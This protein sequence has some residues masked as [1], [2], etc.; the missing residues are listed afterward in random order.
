M[1]N[2]LSLLRDFFPFGNT[3]LWDGGLGDIFGDLKEKRNLPL[4]YEE[5]EHRF[6]INLDMPGVS[7]NDVKIEVNKGLLTVK[8]ERKEEVEKKN[9]TE[10]CYGSFQRTVKIPG[11]IKEDKISAKFKDGVLTVD[12]P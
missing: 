12:I 11:N 8:A 9:Y 1:R 5:Q 2:E 10:K 3:T 7:K 4:D 6:L